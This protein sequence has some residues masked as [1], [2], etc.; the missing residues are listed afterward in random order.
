MGRRSTNLTSMT[1]NESWDTIGGLLSLGWVI[2]TMIGAKP[3]WGKLQPGF[4]F[5]TGPH[6]IHS[7][8]IFCLS[9]QV[10]IPALSLSI[11]NDIL[12]L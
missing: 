4:L 6:L 2:T 3:G 5:M 1:S 7:K 12:K 9:V 8:F 10:R 11:D